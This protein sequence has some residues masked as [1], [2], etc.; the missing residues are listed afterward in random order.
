MPSVAVLSRPD[1][2]PVVVAVVRE[3][4]VQR[5]ESSLSV[6]P[7]L[8]CSIPVSLSLRFCLCRAVQTPP[9]ATEQRSS[10]SLSQQTRRGQSAAQAQTVCRFCVREEQ[11]CFFS[12]VFWRLNSGQSGTLLPTAVSLGH[13]LRY[14]GTS[15]LVIVS[16][17][18]A[19]TF[20]V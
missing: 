16:F 19:F 20:G 18:R 4:V 15:W 7:F 1:W 17:L 5:L 11:N 14:L 13:H 9:S 8:L 2:R 6:A 3:F 12:D 10:C